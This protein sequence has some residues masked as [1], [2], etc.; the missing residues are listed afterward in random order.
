M[1][2]NLDPENPCPI[3][4][5]NEDNAIMADKMCGICT[6]CGQTICGDCWVKLMR[7]GNGDKCPVCRKS[8]KIPDSDRVIQL[9]QLIHDRESGRHTIHAQCS[10]GW[11]YHNGEGVAEDM[12][13]GARLMKLSAEGGFA[14]AQMNLGVYYRDGNGVKQ[15]NIKAMKWI[16]AAIVQKYALAQYTLGLMFIN[17]ECVKQ[18]YTEARRLYTLSAN[19]GYDKAQANLGVM[20]YEGKGGIVDITECA[21]WTKRAADQGNKPAIFNLPFILNRLF[22]PGSRVNLVRRSATIL[23]CINGVVDSTSKGKL[24]YSG[25]GR[26]A[27][28]LDGIGT[29]SVSFENLIRI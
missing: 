4:Y 22:P 2:L 9:Q 13:S 3:C 29:K 26:I 6:A 12:I 8:L 24:V 15:D 23:K 1:S 21:K 27:V 28:V 5:E 18:N 7:S 17:G 16:L 14:M 25:I 19:Q 20:Q 11:M 10:L